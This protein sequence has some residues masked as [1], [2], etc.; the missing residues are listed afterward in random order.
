M[1]DCLGVTSTGTTCGLLGTVCVCVCGG[2][3]GGGD[4]VPMNNSFQALPHS[5]TEETVSHH[6]NNRC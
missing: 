6:Q 2:G 1:I 5:K 4:L 3:G